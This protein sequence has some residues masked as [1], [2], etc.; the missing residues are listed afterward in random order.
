MSVLWWYAP[1]TSPL[2]PGI[3]VGPCKALLKTIKPLYTNW[4]TIITGRAGDVSINMANLIPLHAWISGNTWIS[5]QT[6]ERKML[7][8]NYTVF[9]GNSRRLM[10][11]L[12][13]CLTGFLIYL[14]SFRTDGTH[15]ALK[16]Q[17]D[18]R[19]SH[20]QQ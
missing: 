15:R 6:D 11:S 14:A 1:L 7:A 17:K 19:I 2:V 20:R 5:L 16:E 18:Y 13:A 10:Q 3:P 12:S 8:E 4:N 9:I